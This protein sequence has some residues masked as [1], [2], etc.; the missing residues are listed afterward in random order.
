[1]PLLSTFTTLP[2]A[3]GYPMP[4]SEEFGVARY[5]RDSYVLPAKIYR[6]S[7]WGADI[8]AR[9]IVIYL[10]GS[11]STDFITGPLVD[12]LIERGIAVAAVMAPGALANPHWPN[13]TGDLSGPR[14]RYGYGNVN[15]PEFIGLFCKDAWW[16]ET[17]VLGIS[18]L[19]PDNPKCLLGH[20]RGGSASLAWSAG[21]AARKGVELDQFNMK[22]V[23]SSGATVAGLG[24][25]SWN[26]MNRNLNIMSQIVAN[27]NARKHLLCYADEDAFGPPDYVQRLKLMAPTASVNERGTTY[28][29]S[30]GPYGHPWTNAP[31]SAHQAAQWALEL[32]TDSPI[33]TIA[34]VPAIPGTAAP[35]SGPTSICAGSY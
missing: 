34:G 16:A 4:I 27:L 32:L 24:N 2:L 5:D 9:P 7:T 14:Y 29:L 13:E 23:I 35:V 31:E 3:P 22:G 11:G 8:G 20:S 30:A 28:F 6:D 17:A 1:M 18:A 33:M 19:Y 15:A 26:D 10:H 21:Y 25:Y 12:S